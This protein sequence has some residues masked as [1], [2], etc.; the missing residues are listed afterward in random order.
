MDIPWRYQYIND[1]GNG[2]F[3]K[4]ALVKDLI[5]GQH[6]ALKISSPEQSADLRAEFIRLHRFK[7]PY[8]PSVYDFHQTPDFSCFSMEYC[9]GKRPHDFMNSSGDIYERVSGIWSELTSVLAFIHR[10]GLIHGDIKPDNIV[11]TNGGIKLLDLGMARSDGFLLNDTIRCTPAYSSPEVHSGRGVITQ[12]SD[13][14][15]LGLMILDLKQLHTFM[16]I[17]KLTILGLEKSL[18]Y[19]F[20]TIMR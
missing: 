8:M 4:V 17:L 9:N 7:H 19:F 20:I 13:I 16:Q 1:I 2:G 11:L 18:I 15:S 3:G 10:K 6:L 14:Y 12:A 5:S